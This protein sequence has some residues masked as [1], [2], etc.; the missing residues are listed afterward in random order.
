M[1]GMG[2]FHYSPELP[3]QACPSH[4]DLCCLWLGSTVCFSRNTLSCH[5]DRSGHPH[6]CLASRLAF[7]HPVFPILQPLAG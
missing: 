1:G 2:D 5:Y 6:L 7:A 4:R 3:V